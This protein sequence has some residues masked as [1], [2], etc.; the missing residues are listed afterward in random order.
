[1]NGRRYSTAD[2][3]AEYAMKLNRPIPSFIV[4]PNSIYSRQ[5]RF[6]RDGLGFGLWVRRT[7]G[8]FSSLHLSTPTTVNA[9]KSVRPK[10]TTRAAM[11]NLTIARRFNNNSES[12]FAWRNAAESAETK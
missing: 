2:K 12:F 6:K 4:L 3:T 9:I 8:L 7:V 10:G 1:V 11:D 5:P